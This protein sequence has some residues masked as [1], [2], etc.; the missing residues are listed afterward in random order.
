MKERAAE[1]VERL[2]QA[3]KAEQM[4]R[5][6]QLEVVLGILVDNLRSVHRA[7]AVLSAEECDELAKL[8]EAQL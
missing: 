4:D 6:L 3:Y 8:I 7:G 1:G 5:A 2:I